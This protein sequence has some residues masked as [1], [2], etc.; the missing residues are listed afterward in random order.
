[1][2]ADDSNAGTSIEEVSRLEP[3]QRR[4]RFLFQALKVAITLAILAVVFHSV[5]LSAA[6][7]H[8]AYQDLS[9]VALAVCVMIVQVGLGGTRW[10]IILRRLGAPPPIWETLRLFYI[11]IFFN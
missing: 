8:V 4:W 11:A 10:L 7:Q 2:T 6:W 5:D 9:L 3:R 1:M